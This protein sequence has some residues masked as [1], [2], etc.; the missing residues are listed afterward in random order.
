MAAD[1]Q[2]TLALTTQ[3]Q[4]NRQGGDRGESPFDELFVSLE[5]PSQEEDQDGNRCESPFD[6]LFVSLESPSQEEDQDGNR[7]E[8][9]FDELFV[10]LES[11]TQDGD[12]DGDRGETPFDDLFGSLLDSPDQA[13]EGVEGTSESVEEHNNQNQEDLKSFRQKK[14]YVLDELDKLRRQLERDAA[15][16]KEEDAAFL[17]EMKTLLEKLTKGRH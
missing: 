4:E 9:P 7:C 12:Q 15:I 13:G 16:Q 2:V 1:L 6:E 5:S 10:S 3:S 17:H 14:V 8:S 11:P